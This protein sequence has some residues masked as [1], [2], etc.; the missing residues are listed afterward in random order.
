M[1]PALQRDAAAA[2]LYDLLYQGH[3]E[4]G[5][6][7]VEQSCIARPVKLLKNVGLVLFRNA[8]ASVFNRSLYYSSLSVRCN[9]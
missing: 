1:F 5:A 7:L 8:D 6:M 3:A 9:R 4:S 2:N